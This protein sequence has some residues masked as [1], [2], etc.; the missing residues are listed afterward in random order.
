MTTYGHTPRLSEP[1]N[2]EEAAVTHVSIEA[3][4]SRMRDGTLTP[5]EVITNCLDRIAALNPELNCF[6][7]VMADTALAEAETAQRELRDGRWRGPLHGVP[8]A[9]KDFYD[10]AGVPTTAGAESFKDRVPRT[11]ADVVAR[12]RQAGAVIVGKTNMDALGMATTG[13]TSAFGPVRNPLDAAY[14]PGGSSAGSAA[15]VAAGLCHGTVDTDAVGSVRIPAACCGVV[16]VKPTF[17]RLSLAGIL[18]EQPTDEFIRWMGHGGVTARTAHDAALILGALT[19]DEAL[20]TA[21]G[22]DSRAPVRVGVASNCTAAAEVRQV[23]D[24]T[25]AALRAAGY[26]VRPVP[27]PFGDESQMSMSRVQ[28]DRAAIGREAFAAVDVILLPTL[29]HTIPTVEEAAKEPDQAV[30]AELTA[31]ANYYGLPALSVP[32]GLDEG[33]MPVGL[34]VVG[35]PGDDRTVL[36]TAHQLEHLA[37]SAHRSARG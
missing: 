33:G 13:L 18:G 17:G 12:L 31:F 24:G 30:S 6:I 16:G 22:A 10:T 36:F 29:N 5:I 32:C 23:L 14:V 3:L 2:N 7:T 19:G 20:T 37:P 35:A 21:C 8:L 1:D 26:D 11:D 25:V 27:V 15:A 4:S 9:V 28:E 34:Q